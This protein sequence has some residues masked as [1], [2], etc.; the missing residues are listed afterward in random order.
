M[1]LWE[2]SQAGFILRA[3]AEGRTLGALGSVFWNTDRIEGCLG[4]AGSKRHSTESTCF[5]SELVDIIH[6][7]VK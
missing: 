4:K 6:Y 5:G 2:I 1:A 7:T 3:L